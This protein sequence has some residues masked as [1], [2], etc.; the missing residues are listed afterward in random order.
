MAEHDPET[1]AQ[2]VVVK[3]QSDG[4]EIRLTRLAPSDFVA[5]AN[6]MFRQ[7]KDLFKENL[8]VAGIVGDEAFAKLNE[9]DSRRPN[10]SDVLK[11]SLEEDG[12]QQII[13]MALRRQKPDATEADVDG[14]ELSPTSMMVLSGDLIYLNMSPNGQP[15]AVGGGENPL[16]DSAGAGSSKDSSV[17]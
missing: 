7:R 16:P 6:R 4:S 8:Q 11:Y 9:F 13:L 17:T 10:R 1:G 14:L 15:E 5:L 3:K 2:Y 12:Q